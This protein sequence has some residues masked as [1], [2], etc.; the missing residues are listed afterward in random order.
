MKPKTVTTNDATQQARK[1]YYRARVENVQKQVTIF[2]VL[3]SYGIRVLTTS[4]EFQFPCPLHGDGHDSGFSAR[5]YPSENNNGGTTY[6]WGCHKSRDVIEWVKDKEGLSFTQAL[7]AVEDRF[8]VKGKPTIHDFFNP[9]AVTEKK[10][11]KLVQEV[12]SILNG[13]TSLQQNNTISASSFS[14]IERQIERLVDSEKVNLDM[15]SVL[16]LYYVLDKLKFSYSR[17]EVDDAKV[18]DVLAKLILK[19]D[20]IRQR[21]VH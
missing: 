14:R 7:K 3:E 6:C 21:L 15:T 8:N 17:G 11:S 13:G 10:E 12:S 16:K 5:A 2:Q 4:N 18:S 19:I 1:D 9:H 20:K